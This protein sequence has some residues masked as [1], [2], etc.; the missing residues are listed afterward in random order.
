MNPFDGRIVIFPGPNSPIQG[1]G[2][3]VGWFAVGVVIGVVTLAVGVFRL[4]ME[5][6]RRDGE[7]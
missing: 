1:G 5:K 3:S 2:V 6:G 7:S 4:G